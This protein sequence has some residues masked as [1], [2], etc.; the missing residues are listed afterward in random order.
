MTEASKTAPKRKPLSK[1]TRFEVFKRDSFT[2]Q[3]CGAQAPDAVLHLDHINPVAGGGDNDMMN[4]ITACT[5]CNM[6]KG[7][8]TL[9]DDTSITKQKAQLDELNKR[10]EQLAMMLE[11][12][13]GLAALGELQI[14]ALNAAFSRVTN[15]TLNEHG[16]AMVSKWLKKHTLS[17]LLD[18][19]EGAL[20]TYFKNG[21]TDEIENNKLAG[22]AF[23]MVGRVAAARKRY[24]DKPY[25]K[26]L[27]YTRAIIRNRM[28]CNERVCMDL[29]ERAHNLGAHFEELKE[30]ALSARN[31]TDWRLIME[32]WIDQLEACQ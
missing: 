32:D 5:A 14:D 18:G 7:A 4:L 24:A 23:N 25:M 1:K 17:D 30:C 29:L 27:F 15:C 6:G 28:Y 9:A 20:E 22:A 16:R 13:E 19:L 8:R 3:Y 26:D 11:W 21:S 12:R 2:C 31:W 10:R